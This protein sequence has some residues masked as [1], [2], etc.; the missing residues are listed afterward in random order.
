[1]TTRYSTLSE[2]LLSLRTPTGPVSVT[3]PELLSRLGCA[4]PL[5]YAAL[6]AHQQHGWHA[7]LVQLGALCAHHWGDRVLERPPEA[8]REAL[9]S[10]AGEAGED[11]WTLVVD[12]LSR[13][14][15][16]QP[17]VPEAN[18]AAF[19]NRIDT[20]DA[21]DVLVAAKNHDEKQ[22]RITAPR[23]ELWVYALVTLQTMQ[24]F[25]G[26]GNY[27]IARMNG[28]FASRPGFGLTPGLGWAE[29]FR[30][31]LAVWLDQRPHLTGG[32]YGYADRVG[33]CLLWLLPWKGTT[34]E[35]LPLTQLDPFFIEVCRRVRLRLQGEQLVALAAGTEAPRIDAQLATG[36]T[37][38]IWTPVASE[39][40]ALTVSKRGF[41]Y[42]L[43]TDLLL[44]GNYPESARA[45]SLPRPEDGPSPWLVAE[46]LTRGQGKTDG[47]HH[48]L[49]PIPPAVRSRLSRPAARASLAQLAKSRI[50]QVANAQRRVLHPALC[51]LLQGAP[52][53][54]NMKD[55][56]T[57]PW[58]DALDRQVD[59]I[60]FESL[61]TDAD[62]D[63][64][65]GEADRR[66]DTTLQRLAREQLD[67]AMDS[68]PIPYALRP[69]AEARA[70]ILFARLA[71]KH[72]A[73]AFADAPEQEEDDVPSR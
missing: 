19:R 37:G 73:G 62:P 65:S 17:P 52:E 18:L 1:M 46:V 61:W 59:G 66:W 48:R 24:G 44:G 57:A 38:D 51:A 50:D 22:A 30:R 10:L 36:R 49:L 13:P 70:E 64:P 42:R 32:D 2:T 71:R 43:L 23:P 11:A 20:P 15:L 12:D 67:Q 35:S 26:R 3:L 34:A 72:L 4:Q 41:H 21:L 47:Y 39:G 68:A 40:K 33:P 14:A 60:F 6:R 53:D 27:G 7:F 29:R 25:L 58:L 16:L 28:G 31:D 63:L 54:L 5:E 55:H 45:A 8:W 69:R 9:L 56:R